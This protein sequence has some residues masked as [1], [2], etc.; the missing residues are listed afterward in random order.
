M[1]EKINVSLDFMPSENAI[2]QLRKLEIASCYIRVSNG[3]KG[4]DSA[5]SKYALRQMAEILEGR[6]HGGLPTP[7]NWRCIPGGKSFFQ[8][9]TPKESKQEGCLRHHWSWETL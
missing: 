5:S 1:Q 9:L 6:A 7:S 8:L 4:I 2:Y 3:E